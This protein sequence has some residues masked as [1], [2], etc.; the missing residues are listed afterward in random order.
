MLN[1]FIEKMQFTDDEGYFS[2]EDLPCRWMEESKNEFHQK[3]LKNRLEA[4]NKK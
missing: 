3:Q 1:S 2:A 4:I